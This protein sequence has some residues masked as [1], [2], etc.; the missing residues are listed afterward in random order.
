MICN[1]IG[2]ALSLQ[3]GSR[4]TFDPPKAAH[5]HRAA[6]P[7]AV[8]ERSSQYLVKQH[9]LPSPPSHP[10]PSHPGRGPD[11]SLRPRRGSAPGTGLLPAAPPAP[12]LLPSPLP[13][14]T[15]VPDGEEDERGGE[16]QRQHVAEGCEREGHGGG[17]GPGA[18]RGLPGAIIHRRGRAAPPRSRWAMAP[19]AGARR[20]R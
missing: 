9:G 20:Y 14:L 19:P 13:F 4:N 6:P 18:A 15:H 8:R 10:L 17:S 12:P 1:R 3:P 7:A 5:G 11:G 16:Q 2:T